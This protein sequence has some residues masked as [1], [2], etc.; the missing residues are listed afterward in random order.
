MS[1]TKFNNPSQTLMMTLISPFLV[2]KSPSQDA[3]RLW[4]PFHSSLDGQPMP[5]RGAPPTNLIRTFR[6]RSAPLA[7]DGFSLVEEDE[8]EDCERGNDETSSHHH[9]HRDHSPPPPAV[10]IPPGRRRAG[11]KYLFNIQTF[12]FS[13]IF[14]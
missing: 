13:R 14:L 11:C 8:N 6:P 10:F 5:T 7:I 12:I 9:H 1:S 2:Y 3:S 4:R